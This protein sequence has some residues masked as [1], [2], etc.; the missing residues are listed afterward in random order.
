V[1][2]INKEISNKEN[3]DSNTQNIKNIILISRS[4]VIKVLGSCKESTLVDKAHFFI[5]QFQ[6]AQY[7]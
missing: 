3:K 4:C 7:R 1:K 6:L 5:K 2:L